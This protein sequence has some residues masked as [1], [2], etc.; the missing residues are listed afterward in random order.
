M[1]ERREHDSHTKAGANS[2]AMSASGLTSFLSVKMEP[3]LR[4]ELRIP[5]YKTGVIPFYY[6]GIKYGIIL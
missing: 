1:E 2:L 4:I 6:V 5:D 3:T